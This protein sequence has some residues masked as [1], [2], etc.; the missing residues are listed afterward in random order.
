MKIIRLI[1]GLYCVLSCF[2]VTAQYAPAA[3]RTGSTAIFM[4]STAI[5]AW[6]DSCTIK[7]GWKDIAQKDSGYVSYG[8]TSNSEGKANGRVLSLGDSGVVTLGFKVP[9][10]NG[11]G[12]DFVVF[13]NGVSDNFLELGFV[14]VSS[15]GTNFVRFPAVS[16]TDTTTQTDPFGSTDPTKLNNFAGKYRAQ[17]GVPFDLD[18]LK[19]IRPLDVSCITHVRIVDVVGS[20][21]DASK[22]SRN[23]KVNDPYPTLFPS[24]GFDLDAVGV[25][26]NK[27]YPTSVFE[28]DFYG[29]EVYPTLAMP[30]ENI[31]LISNGK[32]L[33]TV[34]N[35]YGQIL[36]E[37]SIEK[38]ST[39]INLPMSGIYYLILINEKA[40]SK[41]QKIVVR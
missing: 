15:D 17:Y 28:N 35:S 30:N 25:F 13:E 39:I 7:R 5:I 8:E 1:I 2:S 14:E 10:T 9:I 20:M 4:E 6:A 21:N 26:F 32:Y 11:P 19:N 31:Q 29:I 36:R 16:L 38:G 34:C 27:E 18:E 22:D 3:G 41:V 33:F 40:N 37:Q 24:G 12:A 23:V